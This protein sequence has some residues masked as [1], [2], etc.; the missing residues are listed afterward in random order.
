MFFFSRSS[1]DRYTTASQEGLHANIG[2]SDDAEEWQWGN[3]AMFAKG[4]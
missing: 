2:A 1:L 3:V 4:I